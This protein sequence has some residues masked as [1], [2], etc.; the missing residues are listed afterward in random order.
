M[1]AVNALL[2]LETSSPGRLDGAVARVWRTGQILQAIVV[3]RPALDVAALRVGGTELRAR[4]L[5]PLAPGEKLT[6]RVERA[7]DSVALRVLDATRQQLVEAAATRARALRAALPHEIRLDAALARLASMVG[8]SRFPV[9]QPAAPETAAVLRLLAAVPRP[10]T[11]TESTG[12]RQALRDSGVFLEARL[13]TLAGGTGGRAELATDFKAQVLRL[14][15]LLAPSRADPAPAQSPAAAPPGEPAL[16]AKLNGLLEGAL[17]RVHSQQLA[18][19]AARESAVPTWHFELPIRL[20]PEYEALRL[21]VEREPPPPGAEEEPRWTVNLALTPGDLG[22]LHVRVTLSGN[23]VSSTLWAER[24]ETA[25]LVRERL[26]ELRSS[27]DGAGFAVGRMQCLDGCPPAARADP[28][29]ALLR[30]KA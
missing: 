26:D 17:H 23:T 18:S 20:G 15:A 2:P 25:S 3:D 22:P 7:G 28:P 24:P 14:L 8:T 6:L 10:D 9:G 13:A 1:D 4:T 16:V 12:L 27:L 30:V 29:G 19:L 5:L 21:R 11:L